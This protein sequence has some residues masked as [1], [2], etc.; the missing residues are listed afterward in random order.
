MYDV[1]DQF[2]SARQSE[3]RLVVADDVTSH[4]D[5]VELAGVSTHDAPD[6]LVKLPPRN[7][8]SVVG[9]MKT[10]LWNANNA[11]NT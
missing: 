4:L 10:G 3:R 6:A 7:V 11:S 5:F 8:V 2:L 9:E 1:S